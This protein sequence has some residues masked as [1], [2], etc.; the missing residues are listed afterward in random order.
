LTQTS[1]QTLPPKINQGLPQEGRL[2]GLF[3]APALGLL[4]LFVIGPIGYLIY[5]SFTT[6][7]FTRTGLHWVGWGN[8]QRL[9]GDPTFWQVLGNTIYFCSA[10]IVPSVGIPL[11]LAIL[12][13]QTI[14]G[15]GILRTAYFLPSMMSLVAVGL[16]FRWLCQPALSSPVWAMPVVIVLSIWQQLG[17]NLVVFLGGLQT[18]DRTLYEA[19]ALDGADR[20]QM[21]WHITLPGLRPTLVFALVTT[22]ISTLRNFEQIYVVTGGGPL[23]STNTL[24]YYIYQQAFSRF[25]LG[26]AAAAAMALM[27]IALLLVSVQLRAQTTAE[28][29]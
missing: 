7:S 21:F 2:A 5:L 10:T 20:W 23:N 27:L 3:L 28:R 4:G 29:Q 24:V 9:L 8:Y 18:L 19:A 13:N 26:Y 16:G 12:L 1:P 15:K 11:G 14:A 6:G 25:D 22:A 17:F